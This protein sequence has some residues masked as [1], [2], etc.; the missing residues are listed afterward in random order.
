MNPPRELG[1]YQRKKST[2]FQFYNQVA[3][4]FAELVELDPWLFTVE[5]ELI[6]EFDT[7]DDVSRTRLADRVEAMLQRMQGRY[8]ERKIDSKPLQSQIN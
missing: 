3:A 1:W 8:Q 5:T 7:A 4:E 6:T 2:Y